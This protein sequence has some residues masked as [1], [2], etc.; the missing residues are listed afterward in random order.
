[1]LDLSWAIFCLSR[2]CPGCLGPL[3]FCLSTKHHACRQNM[4]SCSPNTMPVYKIFKTAPKRSRSPPRL[5]YIL[6]TISGSF[7][8]QF[9]GSIFEQLLDHF[10]T[11]FGV[12]LGSILGPRSALGVPRQTQESHKELQSNE[13]LHFAQTLKTCQFFKVFGILRPPKRPL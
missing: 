13:K 2:A 10:W 6:G 8:G 4:A 9:L 5:Q 11:T 3:V 12:L 7:S 1:M